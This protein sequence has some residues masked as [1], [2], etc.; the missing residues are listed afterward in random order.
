MKK[1]LNALFLTLLAVITFSGCSD[2]PSPYDIKSEGDDNTET[3]GSGTK[4][5]PY[6]VAAAMK[7]QDGSEAWVM[8]YIVGSI[9]DKSISTDSEFTGPFTNPANILIAASATETNY[10][11]CIPVQLVSGTD[12]RAALNL[13]DNESNLGKVVTIKGTLTGYFGVPGLK[14]PTAAILDGVEIGDSG[15]EPSGDLASLLDPTKTVP[16]IVNKFDN[17]VNDAEYNQEG[18]VNFAEV[19]TR[20][21]RGKAAGTDMRLQ[22][23][24]FGSKDASDIAWFITPA[25]VINDLQVK[26]VT[27]DCVSAYFVE[28]T[29]FEVYFLEKNGDNVTKT[30]INV[31]NIPQ[32]TDAAYSDVVT[33]TGDLSSFGGKT[34]FI[35]F[36]Y[37]GS[38]TATGTYQI[39]NLYVG[40]EAGG[41]GPDPTPE[42]NTIFTETFGTPVSANTNVA[43]FTG[44]DN[45]NFTFT[46]ADPKCNIRAKAHMTESNRTETN[47]VNSIWFPAN[48]DH[49]FTIS[50]IDASNYS[51]FIVKYELG[52]NVFGAGSSIDLNVLKVSLNDVE[53]TASSKIVSKDNN[54]ANV[55]FEMQVEL[56]VKG[57]ASSTLKFSA[58]GADNTM[59]FILYNVRLIGVKDGGDEPTPDS[60]YTSNITMPETSWSNSSDAA[61]G[62]IVKIGTDATEYPIVKLG[63]AKLAGVWSSPALGAAKSKLAF[64]AVGWKGKSG[65]LTVTIENGGAFEGGE[66]SK[67]IN[68]AGNDGATGNYPFT[69]TPADSDYHEFALTGITATSTIKFKTA[70]ESADKRAVIFGIN[71]N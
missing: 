19:G 47:K 6:D 34:G 37:T 12:V 64:Y 53:G 3:V 1:I 21:W 62:G 31:G 65:I 16:S 14:S 46:V 55:F 40:V 27:F 61:Y 29:K 36:K 43:N 25:L 11:N 63:T 44:W 4:E 30:L 26:K 52:A 13:K 45:Q 56:N 41:E 8:G 35:G 20:T 18:Y 39:D 68:L 10:K 22:A 67:Q 50:N 70:D 57:T 33:L 9:K 38:S 5:D 24:A 28:G 54:D 42:E 69:I 66:S 51:K 48:F 71:V 60:P 32:N 59:G 23:T 7:K 17:A 49:S 58:I 2:V 15:S